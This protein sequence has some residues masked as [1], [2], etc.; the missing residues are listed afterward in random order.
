MIISW[1]GELA[2]NSNV[3]PEGVNYKNKGQKRN[4]FW[5]RIFE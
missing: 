4:I 1:R 5:M 2:V 3:I